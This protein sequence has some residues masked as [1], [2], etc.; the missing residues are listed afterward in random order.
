MF[1][2][3][4]SC[5]FQHFLF[6]FYENASA[7]ISIAWIR[8]NHFISEKKNISTKRANLAGVV[9][10]DV[11]ACELEQHGIVEELVDGDVLG[12]TF[13]PPEMKW[14][15]WLRFHRLNQTDT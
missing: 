7:T 15:N 2:Q 14:F 9:E 12:E 5:L 3:K 4:K 6:T 8:K 1:V 10:H 11:L 13:P